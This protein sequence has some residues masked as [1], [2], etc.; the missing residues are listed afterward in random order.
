ME[1][2]QSAIDKARAARNQAPNATTSPATA[3]VSPDAALAVPGNVAAA[4]AALQPFSP[5]LKVLQAKRIVTLNGGPHAVP[6]DMMRTKILQQMRANGWQRLAIT[7]PTAACGKSTI[8]LN[9]AFSLARQTELR[10]ILAELDLRRPS[11][12]NLLGL[13]SRAGFA[14]VLEGR[15]EFKDVA[16]RHNDGLALALND[17]PVRNPAE[18]LHGSH[19]ADALKEIETIYAPD[20]TLFD[21][22]P[23]LVSDD[24]MAFMGHVDAVLLI[25]A[26]ETT[27]IK[28][29]DA[30]EREL[31]SQTNVMGVVLN[32]CNYMGKEYGYSY[33]G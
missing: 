5:D 22:P 20:L 18:L 10:T 29:I 27:T 8:A 30:C 11:L 12:A 15:A 31:A 28:E 23:M 24:V 7:S 16:L 17:G 6:F 4:W 1:K 3:A 2:I 14:K 32:K 25:A 33:Y 13:R 21:M 26:A 19:V 9:L